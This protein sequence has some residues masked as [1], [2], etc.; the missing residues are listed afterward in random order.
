MRKTFHTIEQ[1]FA[2]SKVVAKEAY[3]QPILRRLALHPGLELAPQTPRS[4]LFPVKKSM[5]LSLVL[6][7]IL[8]LCINKRP[9]GFFYFFLVSMTTCPGVHANYAHPYIFHCYNLNY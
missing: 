8:S 2:V 5:K 4:L 9:T 3:V 6:F 1:I 7:I